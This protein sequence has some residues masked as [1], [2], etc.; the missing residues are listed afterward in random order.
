MPWRYI[1]SIRNTE[2]KRYAELYR[3]WRYGSSNKPFDFGDGPED[4]AHGIRISYMARQAV[5]L[6]IEECWRKDNEEKPCQ[7]K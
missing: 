6:E 4:P 7:D 1:R 3:D 2:K 5:R